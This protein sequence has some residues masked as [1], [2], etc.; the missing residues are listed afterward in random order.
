MPKRVKASRLSTS[1]S[2]QLPRKRQRHNLETYSKLA[3][4]ST[5]VLSDGDADEQ[6]HVSKTKRRRLTEQTASE[7]KKKKTTRRASG[8]TRE[9]RPKR[10]ALVRGTRL[11]QSHGA[12]APEN[13][14]LDALQPA[15]RHTAIVGLSNRRR[16]V[17]QALTSDT[18]LSVSSLVSLDSNWL[19]AEISVDDESTEEHKV[20]KNDELNN[21]GDEV[22]E[23]EEVEI[24]ELESRSEEEWP[25]LASQI[26]TLL[27]QADGSAPASADE[28]LNIDL[29]APTRF[30]SPP[31]GAPP[32][33]STDSFVSART[34]STTPPPFSSS[35]LPP[36][37]AYPVSAER[38][39]QLRLDPLRPSSSSTPPP[40]LPLVDAHDLSRVLDGQADQQEEEEEHF[41][42]PAAFAVPRAR[43]RSLISPPAAAAHRDF[44]AEDIG[45][46][47][48][49]DS[50]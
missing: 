35:R 8:A 27:L 14:D 29:E 39:W 50:D 31:L 30:P 4:M 18:G 22:D 49:R 33:S 36:S 17:L 7:G 6:M 44:S 38:S 19:E 20:R 45:K 37:P 11:Q 32:S 48:A 40:P 1:L 23:L 46:E 10:P 16:Q 12:D 24:D 28:N 41:V 25:G 5:Y 43:V 13:G 3:A 34:A 26:P 42:V 9:A 21:D 2:R 15:D 47:R